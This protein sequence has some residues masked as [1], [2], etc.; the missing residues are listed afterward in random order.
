MLLIHGPIKK[1]TPQSLQNCNESQVR[2]VA[3]LAMTAALPSF[4]RN[5]VNDTDA[6]G[7]TTLHSTLLFALPRLRQ[8]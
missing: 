4:T 1:A 3:I 7:I 5:R 8:T 6:S 2:P